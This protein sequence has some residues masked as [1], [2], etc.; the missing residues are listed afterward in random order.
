M[1]VDAKVEVW[2]LRGR[3]PGKAGMI[4]HGKT[5]VCLSLSASQVEPSKASYASLTATPRG[6]PRGDGRPRLAWLPRTREDI[7][8]PYWLLT[9]PYS[10][11][12][13]CLIRRP[14]DPDTL[15]LFFLSFPFPL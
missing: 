14:L 12:I 11:F 9:D 7:M 2:L 3:L 1:K 15:S 6:K 10:V 8:H 13:R 5:E 4:R